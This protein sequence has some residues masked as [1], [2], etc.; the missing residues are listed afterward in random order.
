MSVCLFGFG[1]QSTGWVAKKGKQGVS[2]SFLWH[3]KRCAWQLFSYA[4]PLDG[5][6]PDPAS[7]RWREPLPSQRRPQF[8]SGTVAAAGWSDE[9]PSRLFPVLMAF[10]G[11]ANFLTLQ[12]GC[13]TTVLCSVGRFRSGQ[14]AS[15]GPLLRTASSQFISAIPL[16]SRHGQYELVQQNIFINHALYSNKGQSEAII[17]H[18]RAKVIY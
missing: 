6:S 17:K 8:R 7:S 11:K 1:A 10:R 16:F 5:S 2:F 18:G 9:T 15:R 14:K 12:V 3:Y 4:F 13:S